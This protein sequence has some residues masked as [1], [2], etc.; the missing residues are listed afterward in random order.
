MGSG[1]DRHLSRREIIPEVDQSTAQAEA[2]ALA[3]LGQKKLPNGIEAALTQMRVLDAIFRSEKSGN[4][5]NV[6]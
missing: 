6:Q 3:V 4:W 1:V 2:F 5:E